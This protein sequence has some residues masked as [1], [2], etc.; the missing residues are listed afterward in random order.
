MAGRGFDGW[1]FGV[2]VSGEAPSQASVARG[3]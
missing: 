3:V 1:A 2:C